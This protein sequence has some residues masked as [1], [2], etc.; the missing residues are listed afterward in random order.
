MSSTTAFA[1]SVEDQQLAVTK[2]TNA[3]PFRVRPPYTLFEFQ[4][5]PN[6]LVSDR[7]FVFNVAR[8]CTKPDNQNEYFA[9]VASK[10][11]EDVAPEVAP[12]VAPC[13]RSI[14]YA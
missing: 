4:H 6:T 1:D 10:I 5:D 12:D 8:F 9:G 3:I 2:V 7:W 13:I 11:D 14:E